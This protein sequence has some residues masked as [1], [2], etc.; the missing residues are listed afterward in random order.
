MT[1]RIAKHADLPL[2]IDVAG[3]AQ[4]VHVRQA[5]VENCDPF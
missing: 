2:L 5:R 1:M 3:W 4:A